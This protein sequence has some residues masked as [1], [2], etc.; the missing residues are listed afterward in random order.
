MGAHPFDDRLEMEACPARPVAQRGAVEVEALPPVDLGLAV[1]RQMVAELGDDDVGDQRLGGQAARHEALRGVDL[2]DRTPAA[3]AGVPRPPCHEHPEL[4][5]HDVEALRDVLAD[6]GHW[7]TT[8][9]AERR[10]RLD[11]PLDP[12]QVRGEPAAVAVDGARL[13]ARR[14]QRRAGPLLGGLQHALRDLHVLKRQVV[15]VGAQLLRAR[16]ELPAPQIV[17]DQLQP[18]PSLLDLGQPRGALR[19][20]RLGRRQRAL[21]AREHGL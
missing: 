11:H 14:C 17:D 6:P 20:R 8:A 2:R 9:R 19:E 7:S 4:R 10:G 12:R 3:A 15:L 18:T 1:E 13:G 5:R 16:A 21:R